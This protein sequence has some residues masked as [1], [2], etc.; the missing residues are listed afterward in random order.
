MVIDDGEIADMGS[1]Q[2]LM[3]SN[4]LYRRLCELQSVEQFSGSST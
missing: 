4:A 2:S 3:R 1:H